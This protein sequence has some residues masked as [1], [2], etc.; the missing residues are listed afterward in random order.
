MLYNKE[1]VETYK[2][3]NL[4]SKDIQKII[5]NETKEIMESEGLKYNVIF[6]PFVYATHCHKGYTKKHIQY[7]GICVGSI[8]KNNLRSCPAKYFIVNGGRVK[9]LLYNEPKIVNLSVYDRLA[10]IMLEE[11]AHCF[12]NTD[13]HGRSFKKSFSY[14]FNKYNKILIVNLQELIEN[15]K[16]MHNSISQKSI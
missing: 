16:H 6:K 7:G 4:V 14:L 1:Y 8:L 9:H 5:I 11:I 15:N 12:P 2:R 10:S 3:G 13:V